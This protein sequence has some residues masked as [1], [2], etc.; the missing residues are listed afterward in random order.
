MINGRDAAFVI[1][2]FHAGI[3]NSLGEFADETLRKVEKLPE[4]GE[5]LLATAVLIAETTRI[6]TVRYSDADSFCL[7]IL[8]AFCQSN[9]RIRPHSR[10]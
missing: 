1:Q 8:P 7:Q 2:F 5:P 9:R 6:H 10:E 4:A 3:I